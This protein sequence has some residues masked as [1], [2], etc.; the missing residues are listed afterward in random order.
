MTCIVAIKNKG[1]LY[2]G[3]DS[4]I[5]N[6]FDHSVSTTKKIGFLEGHGQKAIYGVSGSVRLL[7]VLRNKIQLPNREHEHDDD[8][9]VF[10]IVEE[11]KSKALQY[12]VLKSVNDKKDSDSDWLLGYKGRVFIVQSDFSFYESGLGYVATGSGMYHALGYL[13]AGEF[14]D[15]PISRIEKAIRV[16][17]MFQNNVDDNVYI[18]ELNE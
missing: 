18:L 17:A 14:K 10:E 9:Y 11:V 2:F 6:D 15:D 5:S 8:G 4:R 13:A 16:A 1:N 7:N 12:N 3:S